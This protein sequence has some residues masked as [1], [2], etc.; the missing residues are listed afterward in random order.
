MIVRMRLALNRP[1]PVVGGGPKIGR[2]PSDAMKERLEVGLQE[3]SEHENAPEPEDD[4]RDRGQHLHQR[5][6]HAAHPARRDHAQV[7]RDRDPDRNREQQGDDRGDG[8]AVHERGG[9]E[10]SEVGLPRRVHEEARG[11]TGKWRRWRRLSPCRRSPQSREAPSSDCEHA[12]AVEHARPRCDPP[13]GRGISH[14]R[15]E[16]PQV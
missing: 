2:K 14:C 16:R 5:P 15:A 13:S 12:Q 7:E 11:R 8:R 10:D 3:R 4:A 6:D 1:V 9:T